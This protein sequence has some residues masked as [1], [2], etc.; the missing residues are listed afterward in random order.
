MDGYVSSSTLSAMKSDSNSYQVSSSRKPSSSASKLGPLK[1]PSWHPSAMSRTLLRWSSYMAGNSKYS[2]RAM[3]LRQSSLMRYGKFLEQIPYQA[4]VLHSRQ[5]HEQLHQS[6][7]HMYH[8]Q[9]MKT[10]SMDHQHLLRRQYLRNQPPHPPP[11]QPM[12]RA[13]RRWP[14]LQTRRLQL[15]Q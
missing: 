1:P 4:P 3:L 5:H 13:N 9:K 2:S 6:R 11:S 10:T 14:Q 15:H 8:Q 12:R 7:Q